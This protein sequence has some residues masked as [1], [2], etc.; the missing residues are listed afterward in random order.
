MLN[1]ELPHLLDDFLPTPGSKDY[2]GPG[3]P[4]FT[5]IME[6]VSASIFCPRRAKIRGGWPEEA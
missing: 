2:I 3:S 5:Q 6:Y 1:E 4:V